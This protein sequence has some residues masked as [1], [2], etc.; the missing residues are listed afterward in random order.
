MTNKAMRTI[1][2]IIYALFVGEA[3]TTYS[4]GRIGMTML[5]TLAAT[6]L[7]GSIVLRTEE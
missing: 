2:L 7:A 1:D 6:L 4:Q 3:V 5:Y